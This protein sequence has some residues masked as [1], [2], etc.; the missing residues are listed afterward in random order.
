MSHDNWVSV[1]IEEW[2][3][4]PVV[5]GRSATEQ[6]VTNGSA[7]F[8]VP[9]GDDYQPSEF[10]YI[11]VPVPAILSTNCEAVFAVQCETVNGKAT[12][13]YRRLSGGN[14]ICMLEELELLEEPDAR[15]N[16]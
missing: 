9:V 16:S 13:G 15:F 12:V 4:L 3:D 8:F 5:T 1:N 6:D 14:G 2:R 7:V 11:G 10:K